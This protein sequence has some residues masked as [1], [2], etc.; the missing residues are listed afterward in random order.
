MQI[1]SWIPLST[2]ASAIVEMRKS[3]YTTLHLAHPRPATWSSL[4]R[5]IAADLGASLVS[6]PEW[7]SRFEGSLKSHESEVEEMERNPALVLMETFKAFA[8]AKQSPHSEVPAM[9]KLV[10]D[11][12]MEAAPSLRERD[13]AILGEED[14]KSWLRYWRR[15]GFIQSSSKV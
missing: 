1:V 5:P 14:V 13:L 8:S 6:F 3:P 7:L 9:P 10:M 2:A 4:F 12:A 11:K 15:I